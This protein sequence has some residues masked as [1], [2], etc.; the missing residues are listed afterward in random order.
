MADNVDIEALIAHTVA[1]TVA[2]VMRQMAGG[3]PDAWDIEDADLKARRA[4][5]M[6]RARAA[7]LAQVEAHNA[8]VL[9]RER[10]DNM[11]AEE[12]AAE[13]RLAE[14]RRYVSAVANCVHRGVPL[15]DDVTADGLDKATLVA[16][17]KADADTLAAMPGWAGTA[18][19]LRAHKV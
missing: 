6:D 4:A 5:D 10:W 14:H 9:E 7:L 17:L 8:A 19:K 3:R 11:P 2:E 18:T 13:I 16:M 15:P 12:L 1:T